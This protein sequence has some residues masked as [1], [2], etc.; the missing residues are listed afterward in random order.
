MKLLIESYDELNILTEGKDESKNYFIEGI[1]L[2]GNIKNGNN[3]I[4]PTEML[5]ESVG[6][7]IS[8]YLDKNR[9]VGELGHPTQTPQKINYDNVSHKFVKVIQEGDSFRTKAK[10][11]DTPKGQILKN[12]IKEEI[13]FGI[14]S[15]GFGGT[16]TSDNGVAVVQ[17]LHLVSLGDIEHEPSAPDAFMTAMMENKEWVFENGVLIG[18]DLSEE[19]DNYQ[20]IMENCNKKD[21]NKAILH[22]FTDYFEKLGC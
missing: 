16:K 11:L 19:I 22:I 13:S 5:S 17:N 1:T 10:V 20:S 15:R 21:I 4:Y 2:Q 14:S 3:R 9:A 7:H 6:K 18:K 12:L 8:S